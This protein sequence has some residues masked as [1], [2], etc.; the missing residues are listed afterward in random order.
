MLESVRL[1]WDQN[2]A[3]L[4]SLQSSSKRIQSLHEWKHS[5]ICQ[6]LVIDVHLHKHQRIFRRNVLLD[7]FPFRPHR[8]NKLALAQLP[9]W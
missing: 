7:G 2:G 1:T 8:M 4:L 6:G 5:E 9:Q 3:S